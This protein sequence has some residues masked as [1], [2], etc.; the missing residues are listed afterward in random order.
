MRFSLQKASGCWHALQL[1]LLLGLAA[2]GR[3]VDPLL[4]Q[5]SSVQP[6]IKRD[7]LYFVSADF[8]K[9]EKGR[10]IPAT[11]L[12]DTGWSDVSLTPRGSR[13][14]GCRALDYPSPLCTGGTIV[15]KNEGF[16]AN[17]FYLDAQEWPEMA[18]DGILGTGVLLA[19]P[20]IINFPGRYLC[21]PKDSPASLAK[22]FGWQALPAQYHGTGVWVTLKFNS[23]EVAQVLID[24]GSDATSLQRPEIAKL[25]LLK[26]HTEEREGP[27]GRY[28]SS[29]FRGPVE[30][31][32]QEPIGKIKELREAPNPNL[33]KIGTDVLSDLIL[34]LDVEEGSVFIGRSR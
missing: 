1:G 27:E 25:G 31:R 5:C 13:R 15:F 34:G 16:F 10:T 4:S 19:K 14:F 17:E 33:Q 32:A 30:I 6:L 20:V 23:K 26:T 21:F 18:I 2:C 28:Q 11:F 7:G 29:V 12:L 22:R 8:V 3:S 9:H 24:S